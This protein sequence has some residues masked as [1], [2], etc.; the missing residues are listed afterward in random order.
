M[1]I[2]ID[3]KIPDP[4]KERLAE[5]GKLVEI[6]TSGITYEAISGHP[7]VFCCKVGEEVILVNRKMEDWKDGGMGKWG[8]GVFG[9][10]ELL[11]GAE[12]PETAHYNAV[13]TDTCLV[14]SLKY[15]DPVILKK[16]KDL[17]QIHVEQ[18][19]C[20]CNVLPLKDDHFITSDKGIWKTLSQHGKNVLFVDPKGIR[21][22]GF[23]HGFVGG[24][25]GILEKNLFVIG[26]LERWNDGKLVRDFVERLDYE[27]VELY[28]GPLFDGGGIIFI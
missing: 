9:W 3:H 22:P 25:C 20:R 19:Y 8:N 7:D 28:D 11:V 27:I 5:Y 21:L 18:G 6:T 24:T 1:L 16:C 17:E 23:S 10:G 15:T 12:Y 26:R 4:A 14:H 2:I 13:V